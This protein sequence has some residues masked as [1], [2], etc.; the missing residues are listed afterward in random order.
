MSDGIRAPSY[1][2]VVNQ[3]VGICLW[4][5]DR[6]PD[7]RARNDMCLHMKR[8]FERWA[9]E[10]NEATKRSALDWR[11]GEPKRPPSGEFRAATALLQEAA[12]DNTLTKRTDTSALLVQIIKEEE[13]EP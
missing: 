13:S 3:L 8:C 2:G 1:G 6:V 10:A 7:P 5:L 11:R 4:A 12:A 9:D